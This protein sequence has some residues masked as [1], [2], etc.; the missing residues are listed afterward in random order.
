MIELNIHFVTEPELY[1]KL[2]TL[3]SYLSPSTTRLI[4]R[5]QTRTDALEV[6]WIVPPDE[7]ERQNL[8]FAVEIAFDCKD[9]KNFLVHHFHHTKE[10][11]Y[12][13]EKY[14]NQIPF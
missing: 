14:A 13:K 7:V 8:Y 5:L 1:R 10:L 12:E 3:L 9:N 6:S 2:G 4:S 11:F